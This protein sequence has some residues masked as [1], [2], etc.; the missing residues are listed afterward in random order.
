MDEDENLH[1][2]DELLFNEEFIHSEEMYDCFLSR[3]D[4]G[5]VFAPPIEQWKDV[6]STE[7]KTKITI[8]ESKFEQWLEAKN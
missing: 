7:V 1:P 8:D 4:L 5:E 6:T 2:A 3:G